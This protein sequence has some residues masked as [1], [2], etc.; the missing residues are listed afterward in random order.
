MSHDLGGF[1]EK[2]APG[3]F[4]DVLA[5]RGLDC[6]HSLNHDPN[7]M[8]GRTTSGTLKL[9][10]D[11]KG[12]NYRT[13]LPDTGYA[14]DVAALC[15]RGDLRSSSF[16]FTVP[17]DGSGELWDDMGTDE[18]GQR[19]T[20]RTIT[21][22]DRLHDVST[23]ASPAYPG[24]AAGLG[25]SLPETM[26]AEIRSRILRQMG[27]EE[28]SSGTCDCTCAFCRGG[29]CD[30]CDN[31]D[32]DSPGCVDCPMQQDTRGNRGGG[33]GEPTKKV[34]G[35]DLPQSAFIIHG[36]SDDT[37][38]WKLPVRFS[39]LAKSEKHVRLAID[40]FSTLKDVPEDEKERAKQ[41]LDALA[42]KYGIE[43]E[44]DERSARERE[45]LLTSQ[46]VRFY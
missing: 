13:E 2:L 5:D 20:L 22:I 11:A 44:D 41:E 16:A 24:T 42:K 34:D 38:S 7:K 19:C 40:L 28:S 43:N 30:Q 1:R 8:L 46:H 31:S 37:S 39:S 32:C 45:V 29:A 12:L 36:D 27:D 18:E 21:R 35:E 9:Q 14:D 23:V 15:R 3:C 6:I 10:S 4:D 26:P 33:A 25:R 17:P